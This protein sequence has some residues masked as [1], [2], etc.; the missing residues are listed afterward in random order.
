MERKDEVLNS[1]LITKIYDSKDNKSMNTCEEE[2]TGIGILTWI[3]GDKYEGEFVKGRR[4]GKGILTWANG[5]KYE[6]DF[7][8]GKRTGKGVLTWANGDKYEGDFVEG[9]RTGKGT[10]TLVSGD[11]YEGD[12]I[13]GFLTGEGVFS[14][15]DGD[16]YKGSFVEGEL[17][18]KGTII[19]SDG[20]K[21]EG[22]FADGERTG[23]GIF[24]WAGGDKYEGDFIDGV[25]NGKGILTQA[26]G[27]RYEGE[28]VSGKKSGRGILSWADGSKYE[29]SFIDDKR[30]GKG[31]YI[32]K[33]GIVYEGD[34]L[35]GRMT[36][37]GIM[38]WNSG[39]KYKGDFVEGKLTG[40]GILTW[41]NGDIYKGSF[42]EGKR[43]GYGIMIWCDGSRYEG[44]F[45][46][47]KRNGRGILIEANGEKYEGDFLA[48][49]K[50]GKGKY[51]FKNG[52]IYE[53]DFIQGKM[54]GKGVMTWSSGSRY[55]GDFVDGMKCGNGILTGANGLIYEG[56]FK[57]GKRTGNGKLTWANGEKYEGEFVDG[58]RTGKGIFHHL[59][60]NTEEGE[61]VDGKLVSCMDDDSFDKDGIFND[62]CSSANKFGSILDCENSDISDNKEDIISH[63]EEDYNN[64]KDD[65][66]NDS[67]EDSNLKSNKEDEQ[68]VEDELKE[69]VG[70]KNVKKNIQQLSNLIKTNKL[71][72]AQGLNSA[73]PSLH[74]VFTGNPG[75]G[76]TTVARIIGKLYKNM[77]LLKK[78]HVVE[79]DRSSLVAQY[80]GQT[81]KLVRNVVKKAIGG[82]LFIDEAYALYKEDSANDFGKEAIDALLK[83]MEDYRESFIVI[84]AGYRK[85]MEKFLKCNPG[86]ASRFNT[87][88][89]FEDY[90]ADEMMEIMRLNCNKNSYILSKEAQKE[91]SILFDKEIRNKKEN[92]ANARF[93]RNIFEQ[94]IQIQSNR[95]SEIVNPTKENLM[96][97]TKDDIINLNIND[98]DC[99]ETL[100]SLLEEL[101]SYVGLESVKKNVNTNINLLRLQKMREESGINA[102]KVNMHLVFS[103]NPGTGK[104]TIARLI[105]KIYK[106]LG[107]LSKGHFIE[108]DRSDLVG[109]YVGQTSQKVVEKVNE[110]LGGIL[111]IDEAYSLCSSSQNDFG[112]EAI[113]TLLKLMED[114]RD[115]LVVIVAGYREKM[116]E[117]LN[118][119][120]G[121]KS[122]FNQFINFEDYNEEELKGIFDLLCSKNQF[123]LSSEGEE[124]LNKFFKETIESKS[125]NFANGRFVRNVFENLVKIQANRLVTESLDFNDMSQI[126]CITLKDIEYLIENM[127]M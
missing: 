68:S 124:K 49:K 6:G 100:E 30:E 41:A 40:E 122:R 64:E 48:D 96:L 104:T 25:L 73:K 19:W 22:D 102:M 106:K 54:T 76:K 111:F 95:I 70:L 121:L 74:L 88:I 38:I 56:E 94:I 17:H 83:L 16:I 42:I 23:K 93:V 86:L 8:E 125:E 113:D 82:V 67:N 103:G 2:L 31:V 29:G 32:F 85:E 65:L 63:N 1:N 5:D 61:F 24:T 35:D 51:T 90:N 50:H 27:D 39:N 101:N 14:W 114:N 126:Q 91:L 127:D 47:G 109:Q 4:T 13:Q 92:F 57:D 87:Y 123:T 20:D 89:D 112:Q 43:T 21:Y 9:K 53:G 15:A 69:L 36:G 78:G 33:N 28:F 81:E 118:S 66:K 52:I 46:D 26:N 75:T 59:D 120:P 77:G 108:C 34:F 71:R 72:E 7:I 55:E 18:G 3:N 119:N 80:V 58:K 44:E 105:G 79:V 10:L 45:A 99:D 97:I 62:G 37:K 117:F 98:N 60:G 12:F 84:V 11:K 116:Q 115:N 107:L 110:A